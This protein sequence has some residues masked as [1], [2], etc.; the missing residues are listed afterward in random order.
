MSEYTFI[1]VKP[2]GYK[3]RLVGEVIS[4]FE[5][6]G[7]KLLRIHTGIPSKELAE[8][9]YEEHKDKDFFEKLINFITSGPVV[10]MLWEGPGIIALSRKI[11]GATDPFMRIPGTIRGDLSN[12]KTENIVHASDSVDAAKREIKIWFDLGSVI[13][14][15][16][17]ESK[18]IPEEN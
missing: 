16:S 9:H 11:V 17:D 18:E 1:M 13:K 15:K 8:K 10:S 12:D 5:K 7:F 3:R 4:R 2:D 6:K 14:E